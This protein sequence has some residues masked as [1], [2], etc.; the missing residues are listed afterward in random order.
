MSN[1]ITKVLIFVHSFICR[2][3]EDLG[4]SR[5]QS[6]VRMCDE[7]VMRS[8]IITSFQSHGVK[9]NARGRLNLSVLY[10]KE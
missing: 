8:L 4:K 1:F 10:C 5:L 3:Q 7:F 6:L 2:F 9:E